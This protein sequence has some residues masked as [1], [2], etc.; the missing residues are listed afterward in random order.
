MSFGVMVVAKFR[1]TISI[2]QVDQHG[3]V[4]PN[5]VEVIHNARPRWY[6]TIQVHVLLTLP[7]VNHSVESNITKIGSHAIRLLNIRFPTQR[8]STLV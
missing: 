2:S 8:G 5:M 7:L 3:H 4:R 1:D 6:S